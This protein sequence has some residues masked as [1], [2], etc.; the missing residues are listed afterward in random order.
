[1]KLYYVTFPDRDALDAITDHVIDNQLAACVVATDVDSVYIWDG[2]RTE[3]DEIAAL[4]KTSERRADDFV[5]AVEDRHPY[6]VPC[7]LELTAASTKDYD[8]WVHEATDG[9]ADYSTGGETVQIRFDVGPIIAVDAGM[10][11]VAIADQLLQKGVSDALGGI[12]QEIIAL[13]EEYGPDDDVAPIRV[14]DDPA[15][16]HAA[17]TTDADEPVHIALR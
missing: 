6:D 17:I 11:P 3:D 15:T 2:E 10:T 5:T 12:L 14:N 16:V 8:A 4:F 9:V 13:G 7:I 1:M